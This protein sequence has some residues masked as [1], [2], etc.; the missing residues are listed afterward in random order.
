MEI[1]ELWRELAAIQRSLDALA[2]R[3]K[4]FEHIPTNSQLQNPLKD[5]ATSAHRQAQ[6][7]EHNLEKLPATSQPL[8]KQIGMRWMVVVGVLAMVIALGYEV[9]IAMERG[10]INEQLRCLVA[11]LFGMAMF[12]LGQRLRSR[13]VRY[14][15]LL[16]SGGVVG[17]FVGIYAAYF[18]YHLVEPLTALLAIAVTAFGSALLSWRAQAQAPIYLGLLGAYL[19]PF[20]VQTLGQSFPACLNYLL[21]INSSYLLIA[22]VVRLLPLHLLA[23]YASTALYCYIW[24]VQFHQPQQ[25]WMKAFGFQMLQ[26]FLFGVATLMPVVVRK[27]RLS[28]VETWML[29][30]AIFLFYYLGGELIVEHLPAWHPVFALLVALFV[31]GLS[32][33]GR[34]KSGE[35][36]SNHQPTYMTIIAVAMMTLH[37]AYINL[38]QAPLSWALVVWF[39]LVAYLR[40]K[41]P[42]ATGMLVLTVCGF[43]LVTLRLCFDYGYESAAIIIPFFNTQ[44]VLI[45]VVAFSLLYWLVPTTDK[46]A[47]AKIGSDYQIVALVGHLMVFD[48]L[49]LQAKLWH[50]GNYTPFIVT[51]FWMT[52]AAIHFAWGQIKNLPAVRSQALWMFAICTFK[53]FLFDTAGHSTEVKT[54]SYFLPS[55]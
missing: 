24:F 4:Q 10:W 17:V 23:L 22:Y 54:A 19:A 31:L 18:L 26:L 55:W 41:F 7:E 5:N 25:F 39:Y 34:K 11:I 29:F 20:W 9:R 28:S 2:Q 16:M 35:I 38:V 32:Q 27:Q 45:V 43:V 40:G 14:G 21:I 8:E 52:Y 44:F 50:F 49:Y 33:F 30:P 3:L 42:K 53:V 12:G 48:A 46:T 37:T 15:E 36:W 47:H 51:F 1:N 13:Y 6:A